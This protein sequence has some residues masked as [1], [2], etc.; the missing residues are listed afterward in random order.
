MRMIH[1]LHSLRLQLCLASAALALLPGYASA[2]LA[3]THVPQLARKYLKDH[4]SHHLLTPEVEQRTIDTYLRRLD[5]SRSQ[6]LEGEAVEAREAL[7]GV[8]NRMREGDC[9]QLFDLHRSL[10]KRHQQA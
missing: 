4:V 5:P 2:Q 6:L 8:F 9:S 10:A 7:A 3:C 1:R